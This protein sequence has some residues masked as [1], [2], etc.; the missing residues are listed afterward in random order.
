MELAGADDFP[1][2]GGK[3]MNDPGMSHPVLAKLP[4]ARGL[5]VNA[6]SGSRERADARYRRFE[7]DIETMESAA[8]F[9]YCLSEQIP[10][11][12]LR[13]ISNIAGASNKAEWD[14]TGAIQNIC[15]TVFELLTT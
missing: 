5:T 4:G 14:M 1:F 3:L 9:Y 15:G 12:A 2:K 11:T 6:C 8:V 13:A 10:F 7:A